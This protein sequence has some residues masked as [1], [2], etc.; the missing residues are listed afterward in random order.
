MTI[1]AVK[2]HTEHSG[3]HM[4]YFSFMSRLKNQL[5]SSIYIIIINNT[6]S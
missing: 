4:Q 3:L 2:Q 6:T 1:H 5:F